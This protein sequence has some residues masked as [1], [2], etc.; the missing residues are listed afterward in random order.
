MSTNGPAF[1]IGAQRSGTTA[2]GH[3]VAAGFASAGFVFTVNA[4]LPLLLLRWCTERD[5]RHRHFRSDQLYDALATYEKATYPD[6]WLTRARRALDE[7]AARIA[8][9]K[10]LADSAVAEAREICART[11]G[12]APWGDKYNEYLLDLAALDSLFPDAR[13]IFLAR[14]P[15]DSVRSM[16]TWTKSCAWHPRDVEDC[17]EKWAAWNEEWLAFR[18]RVPTARRVELDY[19]A[20]CGGDAGALSEL[21]G[22]DMRPHLRSYCK[23]S[24]RSGSCEVTPRA[25]TVAERLEEIGVFE[26]A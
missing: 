26:H 4:R 24:T 22:I 9:G 6:G 25:R 12:S 15:A 2:L 5:V 19:D 21:L 23:Q 11:Y 16:L 3:A 10:P 18:H 8:R 20:I 7:S 1:V 14:R 17:S 13:W